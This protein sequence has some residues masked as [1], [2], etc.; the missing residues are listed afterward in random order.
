MRVGNGQWQHLQSEV[1]GLR[2]DLVRE[3]EENLAL[4]AMKCA[5]SCNLQSDLEREKRDEEAGKDEC[6]HFRNLQ[7][8]L[9]FE[10]T[11]PRETSDDISFIWFLFIWWAI[12][13]ID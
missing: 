12:L 11:K 10:K 3:K 6:V 13:E 5:N 1:E 7:T 2:S 8:G 9:D 4:R